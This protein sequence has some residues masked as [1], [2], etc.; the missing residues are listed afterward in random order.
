MD[1][2]AGDEE[3][4]NRASTEKVIG[5][6]VNSKTVDDQNTR[7]EFQKYLAEKGIKISGRTSGYILKY[8]VAR[9]HKPAIYDLEFDNQLNTA[10]KSF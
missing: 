2:P 1:F 5:T 6:F 3:E 10:L 9:F 8:E 7:E 4:L